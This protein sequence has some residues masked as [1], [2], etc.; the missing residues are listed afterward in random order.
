M[1]VEHYD[2][3]QITIAGQDYS[4]DV[5]IW[6]D[7]V[8]SPWWRKEGHCLYLEDLRDVLQTPPAKLIIGTGSKS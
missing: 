3:G 1:R 6:P 7:R 2:F 4:K 5:I 8:Y